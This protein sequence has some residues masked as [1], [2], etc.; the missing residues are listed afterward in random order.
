LTRGELSI[1]TES[2]QYKK[3]ITTL[4]KNRKHPHDGKNDNAG[5][6]DSRFKDVDLE[7]LMHR[8]IE[9]DAFLAKVGPERFFEFIMYKLEQLS[10]T[11]NYNRA[12]DLSAE[13]YNRN[14]IDILPTPVRWLL[15]HLQ[16]VSDAAVA[17]TTNEARSKMTRVEGFLEVQYKKKEF[18]KELAKSLVENEDMKLIVTKC[19]ELMRSELR[20]V[21]DDNADTE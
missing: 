16:I 9:I 11:R 15:E 4:V 21:G 17:K 10:P 7:F 12:I 8:H 19:E 2:N 18:K 6:A 3:Y 5:K 14:A 20:R 1:P 13:F